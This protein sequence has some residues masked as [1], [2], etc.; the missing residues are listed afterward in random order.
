MTA[1][2]VETCCGH[3]K[4]TN[5]RDQRKQVKSEKHS[6]SLSISTKKHHDSL[7]LGARGSSTALGRVHDQARVVHGT[8]SI[9]VLG[10]VLLDVCGVNPLDGLHETKYTNQR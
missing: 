9:W 10:F 7:R 6:H 8:Q 4:S 1:E 2:R 5:D 3:Y